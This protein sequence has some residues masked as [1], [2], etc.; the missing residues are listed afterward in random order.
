MLSSGFWLVAG[1]LVPVG[2]L[3]GLFLFFDA[4]ARRWSD[5]PWYAFVIAGV[6][7]LVP[8]ILVLVKIVAGGFSN[9][10]PGF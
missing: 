1:G 8:V 6:V 10:R 9:V 3:A 7:I 2:A 4:R 5:R